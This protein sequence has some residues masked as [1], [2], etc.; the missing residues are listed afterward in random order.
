MPC[1]PGH[2]RA[3]GHPGVGEGAD[4]QGSS[5][6]P[7][8]P[9]AAESRGLSLPPHGATREA[10]LQATLLWVGTNPLLAGACPRGQPCACRDGPGP[11][12]CCPPSL[13]ARPS[14][15]PPPATWQGRDDIPVIAILHRWSRE[16]ACRSRAAEEHPQWTHRPTAAPAVSPGAPTGGRRHLGPASARSR[17][18]SDLWARSRHRHWR[19]QPP[20]TATAFNI[21]LSLPRE[22][23]RLPWEVGSEPL[24]QW[25][26]PGGRP[27]VAL[28]TGRNGSHSA[29]ECPESQMW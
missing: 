8:C 28:R 20:G 24:A 29:R 15:G 18:S 7:A 12:R 11:S 21:K 3:Q 5:P 23:T 17:K 10:A 13:T 25:L 1:S 16:L 26:L 19:R 4:P 2:G 27:V 14:E 9:P 6:A 22:G